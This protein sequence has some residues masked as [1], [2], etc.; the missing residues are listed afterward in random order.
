MQAR[1]R[2]DL[3]AGSPPCTPFCTLLHLSKTQAQIEEM[4]VE[5][6]EHARVCVDAY[7]RQLDMGKHFLHEHPAHSASWGMP[8]LQQ[9]LIGPIML[10]QLKFS[11]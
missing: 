9:L 7:S 6:K 10:N 1:H 5:G 8:E 11:Y 4:Q 2:P 3:L